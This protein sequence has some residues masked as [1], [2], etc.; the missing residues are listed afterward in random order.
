MRLVKKHIF[1]MVDGLK[2]TGCKT[3][4][5]L[6]PYFGYSR[7][8]KVMDTY[9]PLSAKLVATLLESAVVDR[10]VVVDLHARR[11]QGFFACAIDHVR[12]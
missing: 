6:M 11:I 2:R 9:Q 12:L 8:D 4:T 1:L 5:V 7:Q 3:L 10:V